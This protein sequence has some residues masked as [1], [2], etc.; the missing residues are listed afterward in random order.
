MDTDDLKRAS[1]QAGDHPALETAARVGFAVSGLMHLLIGW[2]ALQ[3]ALGS[4]RSGAADQSGALSALAANGLGRFLLWVAV[5]GF[6]GLALWQVTEAVTGSSETTDRIKAV[7]K[8]VVYAA[9]AVT[10]LTFARGGSS[11]STKQT[12][13]FTASLLAQPLGVALVAAVALGVIGVGVY[14]VVKG[15]RKK[16]LRDLREHPGAG[17]VRAGQVGYAAKGAALVVVG[18]LFGLAAV[19]RDPTRATGLDGALNSLLTVPFGKVL[20]VLVAMGLAAYGVYSFARAKAAA[21]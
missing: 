8:A 2:I 19:R 16:F 6:A 18:L 3:L 20:L 1:R 14:H 10:A 15:W 12:T 9:L 4:P 5:V 13:D 21:V 11:S 17:I 7:A